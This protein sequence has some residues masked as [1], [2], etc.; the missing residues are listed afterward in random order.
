M[1]YRVLRTARA[2]LTHTFY[3]EEAGS[4]A[5][6]SVGVAVTRLDG[7]AVTS[8][9]AAGPDGDNAYS[10]VFPG[11]DMLDELMV[12]WTA[13]IA[14]DAVIQDRDRIEVVG[15]F[16]FDLAEGRSIDS[17]L[18]NVARYPTAKLIEARTQTEDECERITEQS[19]VP[20]FCRETISGAPSGPLFTS[21]PLIRAVRAVTVNGTAYG[22]G[23][24]AG[25]TFSDTGVIYAPGGETWGSRTTPGSYSVTVEYEHGHDRPTPDIRRGALT[26]FKSLV[27]ANQSALSDRAERTVSVDQAGGTVVYGSPTAERTGIP[28]TDAAY[29]R[30]VRPRPGFG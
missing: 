20:R 28:E 30:A 21:H 27:L 2:T 17:A 12:T 16:Y 1:D 11:L 9:T 3:V 13:T 4:V 10:Y 7:T 8:G 25:L 26:R 29:A 22:A 15:G 6:G 14:G 18:S 5:T 19:W 24:L 23:Q